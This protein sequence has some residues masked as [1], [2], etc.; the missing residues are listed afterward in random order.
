MRPDDEN[1]NYRL[2]R[3]RLI[4]R[5]ERGPAVEHRIRGELPAEQAAD[6]Y[7]SELRGVALDLVLLGMGADGHTA[8]LFPNDRALEE[9]ER[10]AVAVS[11]P[12]FERVTMTLPVL[13]A[14][15]A[16]VFLVVGQ[17][18][19]DAVRRAF[20]EAPSPATPASLV[21][22]SGRTTY[23]FLDRGAASALEP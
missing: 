4:D 18:K 20:A 8:S 11:R 16:V 3:E 22:S 1:S 9:R 7:E 10:R 15:E 5:L 14:S 21:R 23:T 2:V 19:A 12:D 17:D 6:G 13:S